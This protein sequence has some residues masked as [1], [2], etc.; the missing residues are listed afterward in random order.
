MRRRR[1]WGRTDPDLPAIVPL[2]GQVIGA[3]L[4]GVYVRDEGVIARGSLSE[5]WRLTDDIDALL[6]DDR[7][8]VMGDS[9]MA[10]KQALEIRHPSSVPST[11][12]IEVCN[13][14]ELKRHTL[15][16]AHPAIMTVKKNPDFERCRWGDKYITTW[17]PDPVAILTRLCMGGDDLLVSYEAAERIRGDDNFYGSDLV[18]GSR[19]SWY[20]VI[21]YRPGKAA[22]RRKTRTTITAKDKHANDL[23]VAGRD[24]RAHASAAYIALRDDLD[25]FNVGMVLE[26]VVCPNHGYHR[27]SF[28]GDATKK[29]VRC[30]KALLVIHGA[31]RGKYNYRYNDIWQN[32]LTAVRARPA[33]LDDDTWGNYGDVREWLA[34]E[35]K[36]KKPKPTKKMIAAKAAAEAAEIK[37]RTCVGCDTVKKHAYDL[38]PPPQDRET[39][40]SRDARICGDCW[41]AKFN[42]IADEAEQPTLVAAA[43]T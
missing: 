36:I 19:N 43:T 25:E 17:L 41:E 11:S 22:A 31:L 15:P 10:V 8:F 9:L 18:I 37:A 24:L 13:S 32:F 7:E 26:A 27:D 35:C 20:S 33:D 5:R 23:L 38:Y 40:Y 29:I 2:T 6:L 3:K 21:K 30:I 34:A 14:D 39:G 12:M 42:V 1:K 4:L 28:D 16:F